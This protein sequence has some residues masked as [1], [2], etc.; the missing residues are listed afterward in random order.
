M[1]T[2][3]PAY[4]AH[5]TFGLMA[6]NDAEGQYRRMN[7]K[8]GYPSPDE[9]AEIQAE[10]DRLNAGIKSPPMTEEEEALEEWLTRIPA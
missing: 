10:A 9:F 2:T 3:H 5:P 4:R 8:D 6:W 7:Q 1:T